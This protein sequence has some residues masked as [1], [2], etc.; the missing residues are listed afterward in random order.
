[1][2]LGAPRGTLQRPRAL[3]RA[4]VRVLWRGRAPERVSA[5][6]SGGNA[7]ADA[8]HSRRRSLAP[9]AARSG[10]AAPLSSPRSAFA[11]ASAPLL[12]PGG[13]R[14]GAFGRPSGGAARAAKGAKRADKGSSAADDVPTSKD[15]R[16]RALSRKTSRRKPAT[17]A[18][19][20]P[21]T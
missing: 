7:G 15:P 9:Q 18:E 3:H 13:A 20:A 17:A 5:S 11:G 12:A 8:P 14:R 1:M 10:C 4:C 21:A 2:L 16:V 19:S 6:V